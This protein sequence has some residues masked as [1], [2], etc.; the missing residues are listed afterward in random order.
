MCGDIGGLG[1]IWRY[2]GSGGYMGSVGSS[3]GWADV[4]SAGSGVGSVLT[5]AP[6]ELS[7]KSENKSSI[8]NVLSSFCTWDASAFRF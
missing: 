3:V 4:H 2:R 7:S 8:F 1:G 5:P 6:S